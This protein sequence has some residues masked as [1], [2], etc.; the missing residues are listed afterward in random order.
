[1]N[2]LE[3]LLRKIG[4][5]LADK[6]V[7][8]FWKVPEEMQQTPCDF[9]GYTKTGRAILIE[10]KKVN[11]PRLPI[12]TSPGLKIHQW[13][14]LCDANRARAHGI[15]IWQRGKQFKLIYPDTITGKSLACTDGNPWA[16]ERLEEA[17]ACVLIP[18]AP[19]P[20]A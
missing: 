13:N 9:F 5:D 3:I 17:L 1:M 7:A 18:P 16:I 10:A 19:L 15:L 12:G 11:R 14:E 6:Q 8:R 20:P 2:S 4:R